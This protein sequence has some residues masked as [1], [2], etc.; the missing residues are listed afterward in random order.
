MKF[1]DKIAHLKIDCKMYAIH[2]ISKAWSNS[3]MD[4][5]HWSITNFRTKIN[6]GNK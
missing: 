4:Y 2:R 3:H 5:L 6:K 1:E